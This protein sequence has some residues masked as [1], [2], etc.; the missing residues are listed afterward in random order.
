MSWWLEGREVEPAACSGVEAVAAQMYQIV[1][2]GFGVGRIIRVGCGFGAVGGL[3]EVMV[4]CREAG[5]LEAGKVGADQLGQVGCG[6][7]DGTP[8]RG[9]LRLGIVVTCGST[10]YRGLRCGP[11]VG[12]AASNSL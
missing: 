10:G 11:L 2:E 5:M 12:V 4:K 7:G 3:L 1:E 9:P 8:I 6:D